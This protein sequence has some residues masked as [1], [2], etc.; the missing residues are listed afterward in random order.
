M[1]I[2]VFVLNGPNLNLL[3]TREPGIYGGETLD[4]IERDCAGR[5]QAASA[6]TSISARPTTRASWSTGSRRP[7]TRPRGIVINPGGYTHTSVALHDAHQR[8]R[9][10]R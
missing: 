9:R 8:D 7:A 5:R 1:A 10:C 3:G 4:D 6:S 2:P